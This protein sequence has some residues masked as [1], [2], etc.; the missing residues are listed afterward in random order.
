MAIKSYSIAEAG[1][2]F[3]ALVKHVEQQRQP[4]FITR[5]GK[6]IA[7]ILSA[8]DYDLLLSQQSQPDFWQSY[9][10]WRQTWQVD[11]W[12]D[13]HDPFTNIRPL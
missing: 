1:D 9:Q 2:Q 10:T 12:E 7:V 3:T 5:L 8:K 6:T 13:S 11:K 4:V